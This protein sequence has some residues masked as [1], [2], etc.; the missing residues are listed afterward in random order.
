[1]PYR[2][3]TIRC[4]LA[5]AVLCLSSCE[6]HAEVSNT[7]FTKVSP[8]HSNIHFQNRLREDEDFNIIEYLY[9]YNG[10]GVAI[11][12]INNDSLPDICFSSNQDG[13]TLYLNKGDFE[14][15]D[16]TVAAGIK[17]AGNWKTG[18]T[19]ADVNGDGYLDIF[20]CGVGNYKTFKGRN[21][22]F[23]NNGDLTFTD[24][25]EA[26]GLSFQGFSTQASFFDYDNDGDLDMY[27]LNHSVHSI[28]KY[29][30][31]ALRF[32]RHPLAGD[33]LYRNELIPS[34][35]NHFTD[36]TAAAGIYSSQIGYGLGVGV[37]DVNL[38]G[39]LDIYV[40]NDFRENDYLYIN[41]R[42]GTFRQVLEGAMS[43]TSKFSM[44]N[45]IADVN[46]DGWSDIVTLDMLPKDEG[47]IKTTAGDDPYDIY[48]YKLQF[49]Y[50]PQLSRNA[51]QLNRGL[52]DGGSVNF[53]D[54]AAFAGIEATDWSWAPLLADYD[55]DGY[56]DLFV[57]NGIVR[58][59]NDL[60]YI[61]FIFNDSA[62]QI[63][64]KQFAERMPSG[65]V[66][67]VM[68][69]N[70]RNLTFKDMSDAWIGV[71]ESLSNGAAY[72]D[73]DKDGDLDLITNNINQEAFVYRNDL[74][75]GRSHF[76]EFR[77]H[78]AEAN[79]FGIGTRIV[80]YAGGK[81]MSLEQIPTR[82]WES[83]VD[84][85]L[86]TGLGDARIADSVV[87][88]WPGQKA[89]TLSSVKA[90]QVLDLYEQ[91]AVKKNRPI[92]MTKEPWALHLTSD[93]L[94]RH[95]EN[96]FVSF[97]VEKLIPYMLTTQ[98]P[99]ISVGDVNG[100]K[101]DDFFIGGAAGQAGAVFIQTRLGSFV[102]TG[103]PS[104]LADAY[105]EDAG[106][107]FMDADGDHDLDLLVAAGGQEFHY[108]DP[109][110]QPGLYVNDGKGNFR[111]SSNGLPP[112]FA[113]ASCVKPADLDGDGDMDVFIGGRVVAG[114]YG[115]NPRSYV[116]IN[117][118]NGTFTDQT[119]RWFREAPGM[120]SD[121]VWADLNEDNKPDLVAVG[122]WM[123]V[124]VF[125][126]NGEGHFENRTKD[127]DL[128]ETS[129]W[130]N[131][132]EA[133]DLDEDGDMDFVAGN[134][135]L[136]S[137]LKTSTAQP[138]SLL[139]SDIDKN[140]SLDQILTYYNQGKEYPFISRDQLVK[141]VPSFKTRFLK[142]ESFRNV[143]VNDILPDERAGSLRRT[144]K[145]FASVWLENTGDGKFAVHQL[146]QEAQ[147]FPILSMKI[148]DVNGD[149]H[150]D[151][152]AAGNLNAVQPDIGRN[153]AGYGLILLG[154]GKGQFSA[155]DHQRSGF[156]VPGEGR[157]IESLRDGSGG[158]I[159][160]VGRNND[161]LLVLKQGRA[162][163]P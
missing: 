123:P 106:S 23:I 11:G 58:R 127:Y 60:D 135:G 138:V 47:I 144:A 37:S 110:L 137:R 107:A 156:F 154:D 97:N 31:S 33:R 148:D 96:G 61:N 64:D 6:R 111:K 108:G 62:K 112:I 30:P 109:R 119:L 124:S 126:Q 150:A 22:L 82:G 130:W 21:Q 79:R 67:N 121:A 28:N 128:E 160:L 65:A 145:N 125:I 38:D 71:E 139:V 105:R 143:R 51:L 24:R 116:L 42:D 8:S 84:Y 118:G 141:Q 59:P 78:G 113:D 147:L 142:Y 95:R 1:M 92:S 152:L 114:Q 7:L 87:V 101:L 50:H 44:G 69:R 45:D 93:S 100:D 122:D 54:I 10:G 66:P 4:C 68:Y 55:N 129:G 149:G 104:L 157:D 131:T 14:F 89:E 153:D 3:L 32:E 117:N 26:Y 80:V 72:A 132:I 158:R 90:D 19:M 20:S 29:G 91:R 83:S 13:N 63:T 34:G 76:L 36:V 15:E 70:E 49:G 74:P 40:S 162:K 159:V 73:L 151:I 27:L 86:H 161:K 2:S 155:I 102:A 25:T 140:G 75:S 120:V 48:E 163:S 9:F 39:F 35:N 57:A 81:S 46:N 85:V 94:F 88:V 43:H 41:Q 115:L 18:V 98:G 99:K 52:R 103:Q 133:A 53:S 16:I 136:N 134:W 5:V 17:G 12:D 146:P 77:L 56:K